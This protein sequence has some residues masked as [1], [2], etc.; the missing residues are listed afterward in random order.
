VSE[1]VVPRKELLRYATPDGFQLSAIMTTPRDRQVGSWAIMSHGI[2][3]SKDEYAGFYTDIA[4][5]LARRGV[6]SIRFDFRGHGDSSGTTMDIS[7][8]GDVI[9]IKTTLRQLPKG[10]EGRVSFIGTSFG[11][12]PSIFAAHD[13]GRRV[14]ALVLIAPVLDYTRTFLE[15]STPWARASFTT[16]ALESLDDRGYLLLDQKAKLSPR[17]IEEFRMLNPIDALTQLVS[18]SLIIHGDRDSM[19]P[20]SVSY[21]TASSLNHTKLHTLKGADHGFT[22]A[23]DDTDKGEASVRNRTELVDSTVEFVSSQSD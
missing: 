13:L 10:Y 3:E 22:D 21:E 16:E 11:A 23:D 12:G 17:L 1:S 19:V 2:L 18:P 7:V 15:P 4:E 9:D 5:S 8:V 6:G 20:Y 14:S